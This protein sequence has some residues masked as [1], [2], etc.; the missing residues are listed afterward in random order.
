MFQRLFLRGAE[1]DDGV[2][3]DLDTVLLRGVRV[4]RRVDCV[5]PSC[6]GALASAALCLIDG[7]V[8]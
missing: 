7:G 6:R 3:L 1:M 5:V 8:Q 4:P 2:S